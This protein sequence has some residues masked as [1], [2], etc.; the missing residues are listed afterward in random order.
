M[1]KP[2]NAP[3]CRPLHRGCRVGCVMSTDVSMPAAEEVRDVEAERLATYD[4]SLRYYAGFDRWSKRAMLHR[5]IWVARSNALF[6][7]L[8]E[9]GQIWF[10]DND[11]NIWLGI[12]DS[13]GA[14]LHA[15]NRTFIAAMRR[16]VPVIH[17]LTK[18]KSVGER[19]AAQE[20]LCRFARSV[21]AAFQ[22][23]PTGGDTRCWVGASHLY[24]NITKTNSWQIP[25]LSVP[26]WVEDIESDLRQL[27]DNEFREFALRRVSE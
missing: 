17:L 21:G 6:H 19:A 11:W 23:S 13:A 5:E 15:E 8:D 16:A 22:A 25:D 12:D 3:D 24:S 7:V 20:A 4:P 9:R 26:E 10:W 1:L 2:R 27:Q 18:T 14:H